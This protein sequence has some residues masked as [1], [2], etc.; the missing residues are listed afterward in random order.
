MRSFLQYLGTIFLVNIKSKFLVTFKLFSILH[1]P[2][3][4]PN[5]KC[6]ERKESTPDQKLYF[7]QNTWQCDWASS[8][9]F[10]TFFKKDQNNPKI[11]KTTW[12]WFFPRWETLS[13][14]Y[15]FFSFQILLMWLERDDFQ[16]NVKLSQLLSR[17]DIPITL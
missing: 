15:R 12:N 1:K 16:L 8:F 17:F 5:I 13:F 2:F 6:H 10:M 3:E 14:K 11:V 4:N 9:I 7:L